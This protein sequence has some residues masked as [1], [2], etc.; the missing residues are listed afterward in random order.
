MD[1]GGTAK[2][3]KLAVSHSL[4]EGEAQSTTT[5]LADF[6]A[7]RSS[8]LLSFYNS[9]RPAFST[10][11]PPFCTS[12]L[13]LQQPWYPNLNALK[14]RYLLAPDAQQL[15]FLLKL[16]RTPQASGFCL[17]FSASLKV[18]FHS[19]SRSAFTM[20]ASTSPRCR[21]CERQLEDSSCLHGLLPL[22]VPRSQRSQQRAL[23][24][25]VVVQHLFPNHV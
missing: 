6:P 16:Y 21:A 19:P 1:K 22:L 9:P 20:Y 14:P 23:Q 24:L 15:T 4:R 10:S 5:H 2:Q 12:T 8:G 18:C 13:I 17:S 11:R 25:L 7:P 3:L